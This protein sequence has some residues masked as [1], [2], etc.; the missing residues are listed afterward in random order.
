MQTLKLFFA[1]NISEMIK[2]PGSMGAKGVELEA[3]PVKK[4]CIPVGRKF[5]QP[6]A[7]ENHGETTDDFIVNEVGAFTV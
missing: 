1:C 6:F 7:S 4:K 3:P 2:Q 5:V